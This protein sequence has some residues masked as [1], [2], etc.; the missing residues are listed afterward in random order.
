MVIEALRL[1]AREQGI[2]GQKAAYAID[3]WDKAGNSIEERIAETSSLAV[4]KAAFKIAAADH[5]DR[6]VTARQGA[7]VVMRS[8]ED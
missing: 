5:P 4:A 6:L 7:R 3:V 8:R 2:Q 1:L